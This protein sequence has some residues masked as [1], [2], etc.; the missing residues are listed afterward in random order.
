MRLGEIKNVATPQSG[1]TSHSIEAA[2][3]EQSAG[4]RAVVVLTPAVAWREAPVAYR[5]APFLAQ[6]LAMKHQ[7]PQTRERRRAEPN[8]ALA[9]YRATVKLTRFG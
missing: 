1:L 7:H 6:L 2:P 3:A 4:S 8:D 9:A 5:Q